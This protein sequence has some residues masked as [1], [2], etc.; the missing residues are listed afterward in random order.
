MG[1]RVTNENG[2]ALIAV[3][4]R[5]PRNFTTVPRRVSQID[6]L[7]AFVEMAVTVIE[8]VSKGAA[9]VSRCVVFEESSKKR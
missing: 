6:A 2:R 4:A 8:G 5:L 7:Q 1:C 9:V 3:V